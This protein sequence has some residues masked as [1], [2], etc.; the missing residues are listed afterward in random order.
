MFE[1]CCIRKHPRKEVVGLLEIN[2]WGFFRTK[3]A[4]SSY[5]RMK[6]EILDFGAFSLPSVRSHQA[7][8]SHWVEME[9]YGLLHHFLCVTSPPPACCPVP[10]SKPCFSSQSPTTWAQVHFWSCAQPLS[11][12][13]PMC[14]SICLIPTANT[15]VTFLNLCLEKEE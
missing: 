12:V 1:K 8:I 10:L 5:L 6:T 4:A 3:S 7:G 15:G 13:L 14:P 9:K 2:L 11:K